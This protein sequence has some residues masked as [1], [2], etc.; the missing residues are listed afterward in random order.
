MLLLSSLSSVVALQVGELSNKAI[1]NDVDSPVARG[2]VVGIDKDV[3][4]DEDTTVDVIRYIQN[5]E[6]HLDS[7]G[8]LYKFTGT[9][10]VTGVTS[11]GTATLYFR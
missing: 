2:M 11:G 6:Y 8:K 7:D 10:N 1:N 9:K 3:V 5:P 4:I